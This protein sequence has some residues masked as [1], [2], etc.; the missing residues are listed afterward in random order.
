MC[1]TLLYIQNVYWH[2]YNCYIFDLT[3]LIR[4]GISS[5]ICVLILFLQLVRERFPS[6]GKYLNCTSVFRNRPKLGL[7]SKF[8]MPLASLCKHQISEEREKSPFVVT[9]F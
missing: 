6:L 7:T 1:T 4:K 8:N 9:A 2:I 3:Q 5:P